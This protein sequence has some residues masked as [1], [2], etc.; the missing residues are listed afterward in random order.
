MKSEKLMSRGYMNTSRVE[1]PIDLSRRCDSVETR[2]TPS[3]YNSSGFGESSP[4]MLNESPTSLPRSSSGYGATLTHNR[5]DTPTN[6][7]QAAA[8]L[9]QTY[10]ASSRDSTRYP[11]ENERSPSPSESIE[12]HRRFM[13]ESSINSGDEE[14]NPYLLHAVALQEK[15]QSMPSNVSSSGQLSPTELQYPMVLGHD[16]KITRPF[17]AYPRDPLSITALSTSNPLVDRISAERYALFREQKLAQLHAANGGQPTVTNPKMRRIS[18]KS[19][20]S[21]EAGAQHQANGKSDVLSGA[22]N[23]KDSVKDEA[24]FER[25][26]KNNAAAKKSRDRRRTKEDEIAIRATFLERENFE[27]RIELNA[28]KRQL[29]AFLEK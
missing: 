9:Q 12:M 2:K 1:A 4:S 13:R 19:E 16:G 3:P 7:Y 28:C 29:A 26:R 23:G 14:M 22:A 8:Y 6:H 17:K 20:A 21:Q 15:L 10:S 24:Y 5:S 18:V 27:L 11:Y 25:R